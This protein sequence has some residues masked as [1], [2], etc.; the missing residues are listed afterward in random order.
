[1]GYKKPSYVGNFEINESDEEDR[2][3]SWSAL[4]IR[5]IRK[6]SS[7]SIN[8]QDFFTCESTISLKY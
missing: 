6:V 4:L 5:N 7:V 8:I 2:V 3:I 1:L